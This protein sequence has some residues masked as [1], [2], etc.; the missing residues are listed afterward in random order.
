MAARGFTTIELLMVILFFGLA[1]GL[2][3]VPLV[4]LQGKTA[5]QDG[6]LALKDTV[7]RADTQ[8]LSGYQGSAWGIHLSDDTGC[9]TP[10]VKYYL[11]KG[12][13]FDAASDTTDVFDVP[14]GAEISDVSVGGG[15]DVVFTRFEGTT[16]NAGAVTLTDLTTGAT[17]SVTING[18]GRVS[19]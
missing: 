12:T 13:T 14:R 10:A 16:A 19:E 11:F 3:T 17:S 18:Y 1:L 9:A 2:V 7:R 4:N 8:A 5:L 6:V 15:C